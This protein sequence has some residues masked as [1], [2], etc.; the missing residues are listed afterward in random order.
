MT[1]FFGPPWKKLVKLILPPW[2]TDYVHW[3]S[4]GCKTI[5]SFADGSFVG[6]MVVLGDVCLCYRKGFVR[7]F[8][9]KNGTSNGGVVW[10]RSPIFHNLHN[11]TISHN[12]ETLAH[13][14]TSMP[15]IYFWKTIIPYL[16]FRLYSLK[17][18]FASIN[19][20]WKPKSL[21]FGVSQEKTGCILRASNP[22]ETCK[23]R[24]LRGWCGELQYCHCGLCPWTSKFR[25][26]WFNSHGIPY[27][28][29]KKNVCSKISE[30]PEVSGISPRKE[31]G[32]KCL[33]H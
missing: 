10:M 7:S 17:S 21:P 29:T 14:K 25:R 19:A 32:T 20:G 33:I 30:T 18:R 27:C 24:S 8:P 2:K 5:L 31:K 11:Q 23:D 16:H 13:F 22:N 1:F 3:K 26:V 12:W 9:I 4:S 28:T 15:S 6:D